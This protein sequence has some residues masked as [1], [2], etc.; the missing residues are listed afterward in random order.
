MFSD[1]QCLDK[2]NRISGYDYFSMFSFLINLIL[3]LFNN[4]LSD[5]FN[6]GLCVLT[7]T[8]SQTR[9]IFSTYMV[10]F[11]RDGSCNIYFLVYR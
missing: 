3:L 10:F 1:D 5:K 2:F 6:L 8:M 9:R 7:L 11:N 4:Q